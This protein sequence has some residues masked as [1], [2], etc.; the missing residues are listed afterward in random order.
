MN[1]K[2][3][4]TVNDAQNYRK[5][6]S[7]NLSA[8]YNNIDEH[9]DEIMN[10]HDKPSKLYFNPLRQNDDNQAIIYDNTCEYFSNQDF[11]SNI[12]SVNELSI[13]NLNIRSMSKN[14]DKLKEHLEVLNH[15]FSI[16]A[17]QETWFKEDTPLNYF[18]LRN[19]CLETVNRIDCQVGGV[20]L[21]VLNDIDY[22]LRDDL[23]C[24][25][26][27][28]ES[29]FIEINRSEDK[30]IILGVV[31]RHHH[32]SINE[33]NN[34][35]ET[36]L[37]KV[38]LENKLFYLCGDFNINILKDEENHINNFIDMIYSYSIY[39]LI[40]RPTRVTERSETL[41]DNILTNN[42]INK[43]SGILISDTSDHF[44]NF[45]ISKIKVKSSVNNNK[46][47]RDFSE[48]NIL[49]LKE[50]MATYKWN[51]LFKLNDNANSAYDKFIKVFTNMLDKCTPLKRKRKSRNKSSLPWI[52]KDLIKMINKKNRLYKK[53]MNKRTNLNKTKYK[54]LN[55]KV[56]KLLRTAKKNYFSNQLENEKRNIKNT[57]KVL[58][59]ALNKNQYRPCNTEFNLNGTV[60][61]NPTQV[62]DHFNDFFINIG[63]NQV[64]QIPDNNIHFS[65]YMSNPNE[66]SMFFSPITE[67]E[68][69][70][71]IKSLDTKKSAGHDNIPILII[72]KLANELSIPLTFIFNLSLSSG[73]VP[74]QLKIARVVPIHKKECKNVF[75]NYRPISVLP[76]F[77]KILERLVFNRCISFLDKHK[78]LHN[79]QFG[80]RP[81]H[82]TN[83]A[84][85][86]LVDKIVQATNNDE[87]TAGLFLDLSKAFDTIKHDILLD[88]MAHYGIR[89]LVLEWFKN[90]LSNRKQFVDYNSHTSELK[91]ISSGM[92]QGSILG[93]LGF[94]IY[95]NDIPNSVPELSLILYAD[96]TSAFTSHKDISELNNIMNDG[97]K[98]L[99]GWF[100]SNKLSLN[101]KK[102]NVMLFGT[103]I[104][105]K[106]YENK[107][108]LSLDNVEIKCVN[109]CK[110]LGVTI[111]Q[112]LT[113]ENHIIEVAKKCSSSIGI[114]Y[115]MKNFL[116][117]TALLSLYNTLVL[118]HINYGITAWSSAGV[119]A[120]TR[121]H[122]LQKRAL[123]AISHSDFRSHSNPLFI[124]Y[125]Q[126]KIGELC[127]L[128]I[129]TF[130][131]KYCN[132]LLPSTF[133]LMFTTNADTHN[134]NTRF[135]SNFKYPNNKLEFGKKSI[136]YRG[137]E[138]W[139]NIS[140]EIKN[141]EN[142]KGFKG[143][144]KKFLVSQY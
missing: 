108:K 33:F 144:Y 47:V 25:N 89:G 86:K 97:L 99:N 130:M 76:G 46:K 122:I 102:S 28:Y 42:A 120:K 7:N 118:S 125:N 87:I 109:A 137:V 78:I 20:G 19:Y 63:P 21:Y 138:I 3:N 4:I 134:Y 74:D 36:V 27:V 40:L 140:D 124:K 61:N 111:D 5:T 139:N 71:I 51:D 104:K 6:N 126:L 55:N 123:R 142:T 12:N 48:E 67:E 16:I 82:S 143:T 106:Q 94:I 95:V 72:K 129:G 93:P 65:T 17:I 112:N 13:L 133:N 68:V 70:K 115:K 101:T 29:C 79:D 131:Y 10:L 1:N 2:S 128:N 98:K 43:T 90:Y 110:F 96:D 14:I 15:K 119:S 80:F 23:R 85:I 75:N 37:S 59:N 107:L 9:D 117:E 103:H 44:P 38:T 83:M 45:T 32:K 52:T 30:N 60:I 50:N 62:S 64:S 100:Q 58:N 77:S 35:L 81:K 88:K 8:K 22:K 56:N 39:P 11:N 41:I 114:L 57:W 127:K 26:E 135:A 69:I 116:P 121:L 31:Y 141:S 66:S 113:W 73:I 132:N 24:Q 136:S 54:T 18:N 92:P 34:Q 49:N 53:Y 105:T 91:S 84:I